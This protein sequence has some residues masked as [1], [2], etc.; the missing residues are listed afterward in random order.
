ME[1][2][3]TIDKPPDPCAG[4]SS[5]CVTPV[6]SRRVCLLPINQEYLVVELGS[7]CEV[8][9][10]EGITPVPGMPHVLAGVTT[11]R[12]AVIPLIDLRVLLDWSRALVP[13]YA[14]VVRHGGVRFG[15]LIDNVPE[16]QTVQSGDRS[17]E[18]CGKPSH[19]HHF[20]TDFINVT[21]KKRVRLDLSALLAAIESLPARPAIGSN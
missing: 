19:T 14:A 8:I 16:I 13:R 15:I 18:S 12:G 7:L 17:E 20:L 2:I 3:E 11:C 6:L 9:E 21:G 4:S 1:T 5:D 10:V